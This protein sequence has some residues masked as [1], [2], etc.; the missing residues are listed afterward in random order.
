MKSL[1]QGKWSWIDPIIR[2][3]FIS[4]LGREP[5]WFCLRG[6]GCFHVADA[7]TYR[8]YRHPQLSTPTTLFLYISL[9]CIYTNN[10]EPFL[11]HDK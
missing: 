8:R 1:V 3:L 9:P 7:A 2:V 11:S 6:V 4:F 5:L 10:N